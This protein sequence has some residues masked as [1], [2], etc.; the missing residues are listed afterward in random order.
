M[1]RGAREKPFPVPKTFVDALLALFD[2]RFRSFI[3]PW[4]VKIVWAICVAAAMLSAVKLGYDMFVEPSVGET[5]TYSASPGWQFD[6]LAGQTFWQS[7][8]VRFFL[9]MLGV[10]MLLIAVRVV[11]EGAIV[12][13]HVA[14]SVSD[15]KQ[16]AQQREKR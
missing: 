5:V 7:A 10:G 13:F 4:I 16:L 9:A 11:C 14:N 15:L 2:F 6:P 12:F 3:T 1:I 8:L